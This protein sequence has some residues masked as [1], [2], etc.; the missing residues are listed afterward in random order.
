MVGYIHTKVGYPNIFAYR[1]IEDVQADIDHW[2]NVYGVEGIFIDEVTNRWPDE[3]F[4]SKELAVS[5][6]INL[7]A[8]IETL[9]SGSYIVLNPGSAYYEEYILNYPLPNVIVVLF[10]SPAYK[11]DPSESG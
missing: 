1:D 2:F 3:N 11:F 4:D 5:F 8:Y 10:E 7:I 6:S 9:Y